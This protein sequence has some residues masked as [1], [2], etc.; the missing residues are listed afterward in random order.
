MNEQEKKD[1]IDE[2]RQYPDTHPGGFSSFHESRTLPIAYEIPMGSRVLDIGCNSGEFMKLLQEKRECIVDGVDVSEIAI[3]KAKAKVGA[4][5]VHLCDAEH[6]PFQ[7][8]TFDVVVLMEVLSHLVDP[9][10]TL[11]EIRRVLKPSGVLMGSVPHA[12]LEKFIWDDQRKHRRYY[13][14]PQLRDELEKEFPFTYVRTLTGAQF[15]VSMVNSFIAEKPAEML[16]KC[17]NKSATDWEADQKADPKM[18]VWFGPTQLAGT[19]YYRMLGFAEKMDTLGLI[20]AA[21]ERS[22]WNQI[23]DRTASWQKRI[24]NKVVLN[25]LENILRVAHASVWQ[26]V[27]NRDVLAFLRCA[28]DISNNVWYKATGERKS[29]ITEIDDNIFDIPSGNIAAHPYQPNSEA[30]WVAQKQIEMSDALVCSTQFLLDKMKGM[31]PDKP[32][33]LVPN[34]L[35]FD[36]WDKV[37]FEDGGLPK[38]RRMQIRYLAFY[39]LES[40]KKREFKFAFTQ[41]KNWCKKPVRIGYTGCS[42]HRRDL[43][44]I[45]EPMSAIL[46]EF[47]NVQFFMTPQPEPGGFF[48]G[49]PGVFNMGFVAKWVMIN[50]YPKFL[51]SWDL[52]IGVAPLQDN[53]FNRA[54]SNLRFLEYGALKLPTVASKVYPFKYSIT[55]GHDGFIC[56]TSSQWYESLRTLIIDAEKRKEIGENAYRTVKTKYNMETTSRKYAEVLQTIYESR[57]DGQRSLE[58][59]DEKQ[60]KAE[61]VAQ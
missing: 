40:F 32:A 35:D 9:E 33:Y 13:D 49:W 46:K 51:K 48:T 60:G 24:R 34:S 36:I 7:N 11:K 20:Q 10:A 2:Y 18:R 12:N 56:N 15:A 61:L 26:I 1:W 59:Q 42:N 28:K 45:R 16:F 38:K 54:K 3:E 29:F 43:E 5:F 39:L 57:N 17:G 44:I 55:H 37:T 14:E 47:P 23:D 21:Y 6:L 22:A 53:D 25:Q 52:D 41:F 8:E 27:L 30:E 4:N 50:E 31:F 19:V 58:L